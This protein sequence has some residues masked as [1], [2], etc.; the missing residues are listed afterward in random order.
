MQVSKTSKAVLIRQIDPP[1]GSFCKLVNFLVAVSGSGG[2][3]CGDLVD[4]RPRWVKG[5][6][7]DVWRRCAKKA[8]RSSS[9]LLTLPG[10]L[11]LKVARKLGR[12]Q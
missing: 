4:F 12:K 6:D 7:L 3:G 10:V 8:L 5:G 9:L 1:Q 11:N 2:V